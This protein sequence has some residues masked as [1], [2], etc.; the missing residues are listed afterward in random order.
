VILLIDLFV[1]LC[2]TQLP[3]LFMNSK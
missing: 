3:L 2:V 1:S